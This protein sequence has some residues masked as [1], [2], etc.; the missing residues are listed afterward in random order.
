MREQLDEDPQFA[1]SIS[2]PHIDGLEAE[3]DNFMDGSIFDD[4]LAISTD[5]LVDGLTGNTSTDKSQVDDPESHVM[6]FDEDNN[7]II[8]GGPDDELTDT[9]AE[10]EPDPEFD[11]DMDG[12]K[13]IKGKGNKV[14]EIDSLGMVNSSESREVVA[15]DSSLDSED[16]FADPY[17]LPVIGRVLPSI[18]N[19]HFLDESE[20]R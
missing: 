3:E 6:G 15:C 8:H 4:D 10:G 9:D 5:D 16:E 13:D 19:Q 2:Q 11:Q 12:V 18:P 17:V 14:M 1:L 7:F 20:G